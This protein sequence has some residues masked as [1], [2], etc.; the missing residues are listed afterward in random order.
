[1][2]LQPSYVAEHAPD[3]WYLLERPPDWSATDYEA[4]VAAAS[5]LSAGVWPHQMVSRVNHGNARRDK[6]AMSAALGVL[7]D[8]VNQGWRVRVDSEASVTVQ[9]P[10][11]L[12]DPMAEKDRVRRQELAKRREQLSVPSVRR[13]IQDM[14]RLRE[15]NGS[16]VSI[17]NLMRDGGE[18]ADSLRSASR[19]N[20]AEA[21]NRVIDPYIEYVS[22][23]GVCQKTGL[24]L[25]DIWRY[26]RHTW[27]NQ[28]SSTPGRTMQILVRDRATPFH[29]VIGIAALGSPVI[30]IAERDRAIGWHSYRLLQALEE[31]P[32]ERYA[33]WVM[34]RLD[35]SMSELYVEDL[36]EDGL[37]WPH[38]WKSP[39]QEAI[40]R[41]RAEAEKCR[42]AHQ[43][44]GRRGDFSGDKAA[45]DRWVRRARTDLYRS[46]RCT[47]LADLLRWR[48]A[49]MPYLTPRASTE[50]LLSAL[51]RPEARAAIA[52]VIR[53]A[54][55]DAIGTEMADLTVC[56]AIAPYSEVLGG[57]L[58]SMLAVSPSIVRSYH[59]RYSTYESEIAS[60]MA[61]RPIRRPSNLV[62]IGTTSLYGAGSSQYNRLRMPA[63]VLE[64]RADLE[65]RVFGRSRAFGTS[66]LSEATV[67]SLARLAEQAN[68]GARVNSIFGEGVNPKLRKVRGGLD[69]LGWPSDVLL[70]H[71]RERIAY[72]VFLAD[73]VLD[74]LLG[75]D[76][77]PKYLAPLKRT[78]DA[79]RVGRWWIERWLMRRAASAEVLAR[80]ANHSL[81]RPVRHGARVVL[82]DVGD[83]ADDVCEQLG[84]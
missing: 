15:F 40:D 61:G 68:V 71:R 5:A 47:L 59:E 14:E 82:P 57:K 16:M 76:T 75:I 52:G 72:G 38:L 81:N 70:R 43:R 65:F 54:K 62:F 51:G 7:V 42:R 25:M 80:M 28:Y 58:V 78:D 21:F 37:Y 29:S 56:G 1:M 53:R 84:E 12:R 32:S 60:S 73:N 31:S 13:F 4:F 27:A 2:S 26:F 49:L 44:F 33:S 19:E 77:L 34:Q 79:Q 36:I 39:D 41:L 24:R 63:S 67:Q 23:K 17:F 83:E 64:G 9:A 69:L 55:A 30:Q 48:R 3:D 11:V 74:Y 22:P 46:K 6:P 35:K 66:H 18:L 8:L 45:D 10:E 20:S 50:G